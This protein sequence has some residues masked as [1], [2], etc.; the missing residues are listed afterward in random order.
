MKKSLVVDLTKMTKYELAKYSEKI[1]QEAMTFE[2][3][4]D[5]FMY[6]TSDSVDETVHKKL[7]RL[8]FAANTIWKNLRRVETLRRKDK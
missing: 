8:W 5:S 6:N 7:E 2:K 1:E 3:R 4:L